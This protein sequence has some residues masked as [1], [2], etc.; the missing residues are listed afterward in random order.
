M[1]HLSL[2]TYLES[3]NLIPV[4]Q[5]VKINEYNNKILYLL[6][7]YCIHMNAYIF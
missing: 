7:I 2:I 3:E 4:K 6:Y 1:K 5:N